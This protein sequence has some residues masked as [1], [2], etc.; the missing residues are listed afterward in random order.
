MN[1]LQ[2]FVNGFGFGISKEELIHK[3][4]RQL[5]ADGHACFIINE[6]YINVD[7]EDLQL[8][9]SRKENRWIAKAF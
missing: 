7:G 6:K 1:A 3:A 9:K 8:I 2:N 5:T 4:Y